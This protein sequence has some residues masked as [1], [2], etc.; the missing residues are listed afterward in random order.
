M[1]AVELDGNAEK[2]PPLADAPPIQ[3]LNVLAAAP[4]PIMPINTHLP[5]V[6]DGVPATGIAV[7]PTEP[8]A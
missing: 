6:G 1:I 8:A 2:V 3:K 7:P 4:E 5:K